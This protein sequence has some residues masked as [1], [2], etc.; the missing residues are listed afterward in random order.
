MKK[1]STVDFSVMDHYFDQLSELETK[2]I[3]VGFFDEAHYSGLNMATLA[4]IHELGWNNLPERNFMLSTSIHY[5]G[6]LIKNLKRL[7][8]DLLKG[9]SYSPALKKIGKDYADSIRFTIDQGTFSNNRVSTAWAS[10]KGFSDAMIHYGD[11]SDA[12]KFKIVPLT[13]D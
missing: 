2:E 13:K 7:N 5:R 8:D 12:A 10:Y 4:A 3:E 9:K 1:T 11:L 6:G